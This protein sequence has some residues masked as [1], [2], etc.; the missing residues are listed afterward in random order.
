MCEP[1]GERLREL[2]LRYGS[3]LDHGAFFG[4]L[5]DVSDPEAQLFHGEA[6][7]HESLEDGRRKKRE[8]LCPDGGSDVDREAA[9]AQV[10]RSRA[11]ADPVS[12]QAP[13]SIPV[14]AV[15]LRAEACAPLE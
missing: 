14:H 5:A 10:S 7:A 9:V 13:P 3:F 12:D 6:V 8:L 2:C 1:F 11:L 4:R 15:L